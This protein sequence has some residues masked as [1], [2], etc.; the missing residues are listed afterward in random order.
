M[1]FDVLYAC[2]DVMLHFRSLSAK[3]GVHARKHTDTAYRERE[4]ERERERGRGRE[5][6]RQTDRQRDRQTD[7]Q[8][9]RERGRERE[10][11][12]FVSK[13]PQTAFQH[14]KTQDPALFS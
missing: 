13:I 12:Y 4:R 10:R 1:L 11:D 3:A 2:Y 7:R 9:E 6:E 8:G 14:G 5:K